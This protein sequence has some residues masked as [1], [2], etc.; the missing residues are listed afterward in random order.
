MYSLDLGIF[1]QA[2]QAEFPAHSR[3]LVTAK[4]AEI[5]KYMVVV[6]PHR[7]RADATGYTLGPGRI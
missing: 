6:Y 7:P 2:F 1:M 5:G 4:G 3:L